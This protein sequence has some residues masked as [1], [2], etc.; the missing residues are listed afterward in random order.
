MS[1]INLVPN[2]DPIKIGVVRS[3]SSIHESIQAYA[4][5]I[6]NSLT[7]YIHI[8]ERHKASKQTIKESLFSLNQ[9]NSFHD[10]T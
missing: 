1:K 4:T 2:I 7:I 8:V 9:L 3:L 5:L 6:E 10:H